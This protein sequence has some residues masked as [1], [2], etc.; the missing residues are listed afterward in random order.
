MFQPVSYRLRQFGVGA[1]NGAGNGLGLR[2]VAGEYLEL[3]KQA[4]VALA[5]SAQQNDDL[6]NIGNQPF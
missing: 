1:D 4:L 3:F 5:L 2:G 6:R